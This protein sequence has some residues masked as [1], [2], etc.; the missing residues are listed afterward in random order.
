MSASVPNIVLVFSGINHV[1]MLCFVLFRRITSAE[2]NP[3]AETRLINELVSDVH[4]I[5][6][7]IKETRTNLDIARKRKILAQTCVDEL[8]KD[9]E[10][11]NAAS[12]QTKMTQPAAAEKKQSLTRFLAD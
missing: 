6:F 12:T 10:I 4:D 9:L 2:S 8:R 5:D 3:E 1:Y 11:Q 7:Q